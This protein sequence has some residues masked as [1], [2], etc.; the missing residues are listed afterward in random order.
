MVG[1]QLRR[2]NEW[3][4][5]EPN[6][7]S[8]WKVVERNIMS[9]LEQLWNAGLLSGTRALQ[10]YSVECNGATNPLAV[11]DRGELHIQVKLKPV[12][13]TEQILIELQL[14]APGS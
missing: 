5:F 11:R 3:A 8:L 7:F 6:E 12:G 1:E 9:R 14:G 13:T 2:D 4:V 10:E